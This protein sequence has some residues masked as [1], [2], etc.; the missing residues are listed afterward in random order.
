MTGTNL[1]GDQNS[2]HEKEDSTDGQKSD[3]DSM[4]GHEGGDCLSKGK[5][6]PRAQSSPIAENSDIVV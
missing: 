2:L 1:D 6:R 3:T 4:Q 5:A